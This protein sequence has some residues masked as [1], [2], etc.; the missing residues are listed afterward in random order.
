MCLKTC[1]YTYCYSLGLADCTA[2]AVERIALRVNAMASLAHGEQIVE[3]K[4]QLG[5]AQACISR[6]AVWQ[7][8]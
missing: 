4:R 7:A 5:S 1:C 3:L 8:V 2:A 6:N